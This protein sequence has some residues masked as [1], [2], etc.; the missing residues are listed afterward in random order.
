[1][2]STILKNKSLTFYVFPGKKMKNQDDNI[3]NR[4]LIKHSPNGKIKLPRRMTKKKWIHSWDI[5]DAL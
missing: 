3:I 1:M 2:T 4:K 5:P